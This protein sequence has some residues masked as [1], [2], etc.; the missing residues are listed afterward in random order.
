[1]STPEIL[2]LAAAFASATCGVFAA[3]AA[4]RSADSARSAQTSADASE[5]RSALRQ[6]VLTANEVGLEA[7][8]CISYA[9]LVARSHQ[10]LAIFTG[11]PG[12]SR[13]QLVKD[14]LAE[15]SRRAAT[16]E[17]EGMIFGAWPSTLGDAPLNEIDRVITKLLV[18]RMDVSAMR[19]D[20]ENERADVE[21]QCDLF[22]SKAIEE[23]S[24]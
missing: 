5:R 8:R 3:I 23:K 1:M 4:F 6:L 13:H 16:I 24:Q 12:G 11:G 18:L 10:G 15:K 22:R 14:A 17:G 7:Q 2:S 19:S 20:L 9:A 21:R